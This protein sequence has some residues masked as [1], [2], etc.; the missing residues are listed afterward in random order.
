M[1]TIR[2]GVVNLLYKRYTNV[3]EHYNEVKGWKVDFRPEAINEPY[4][5]ENNEIGYEIFKNP[6]E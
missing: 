4:G 3:E 1:T 2:S 6:K 5:L